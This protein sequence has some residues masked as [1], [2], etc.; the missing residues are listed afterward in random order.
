MLGRLL[1]KLGLFTGT[2][3][4]RNN[5]AVFF[6]QLNEWLMWQCGA[7][8]DVPDATHYLWKN[9]KLVNW[10]EDY[11]R[12]IL[13][14][15]RAMHFLGLRR[16]LFTGGISRLNIP[17]GWKDP[18]NTFTLPLWRRIF[19]AAKVLYIER[20]GV[21]VA[22]S[23]QTRGG[24]NFAASIRKY[25]KHRRI[26]SWSPKRSGFMASPRCS[27]LENGFSLWLEYMNQAADMIRQLPEQQVLKL[28]YET[29]LA[30]PVPS[31][32]ASAEFCHLNITS[33]EVDTL[34]KGINADRANSYKKN[35][36]LMEF[37]LNHREE[38]AAK[39]YQ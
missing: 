38:L 33:Q 29:I 12:Y 24:D 25:Q 19:P 15:P 1:E 8:W 14:S 16:Y 9:A 30:D 21:D 26:Y 34:A 18:R 23:L 4:D 10:T 20:H 32:L 22:H 13:D 37:A 2:R 39:G 31:L 5:E 35:P 6:Q 7:R 3:K 28:R 27:S 17:W 11:V 36:D